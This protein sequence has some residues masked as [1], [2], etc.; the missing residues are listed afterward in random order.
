MNIRRIVAHRVELP[1][2]KGTC[3]WSGGKSVDVFDRTL[4][5]VETECGVIDY[6]T[7]ETT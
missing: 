5:G 6:R 1:L 4:G 7:E 2:G 3:H